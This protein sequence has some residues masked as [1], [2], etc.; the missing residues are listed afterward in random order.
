MKWL[1]TGALVNYG[2]LHVFYNQLVSVGVGHLQYIYLSLTL[3]LNL[4]NIH[5]CEFT[6]RVLLEQLTCDENSGYHLI[7]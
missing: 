1:G 6:R 2:M 3:E 7:P 5:I 4:I